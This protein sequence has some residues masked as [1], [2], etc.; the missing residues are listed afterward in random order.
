MIKYLCAAAL[1][2]T[3]MTA[4][5]ASTIQNI[6]HI[7]MPGEPSVAVEIDNSTTTQEVKLISFED[8]DILYNPQIQQVYLFNSS[9]DDTYDVQYTFLGNTAKF[10]KILYT[11]VPNG[12]GT[13]PFKLMPG[14]SIYTTTTGHF[15]D[16]YN[17][18]TVNAKMIWQDMTITDSAGNTFGCDMNNQHISTNVNRILMSCV[19]TKV[20]VN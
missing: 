15:I 1:L 16:D 13:Q 6:K 12:S 8:V 11:S 7:A 18:N 2:M 5:A 10:G 17:V 4:C 9:Y 19:Q 3:S 14:G 20:A